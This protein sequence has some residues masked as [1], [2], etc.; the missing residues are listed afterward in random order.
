MDKFMHLKIIRTGLAVQ[1]A[2]AIS[3]SGRSQ[4]ANIFHSQVSELLMVAVTGGGCASM[5]SSIRVQDLD[6]SSYIE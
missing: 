2:K 4:T 6:L 3:I 5:Y 1:M